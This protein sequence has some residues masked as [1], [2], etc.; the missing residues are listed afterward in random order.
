M[1]T[2]HLWRNNSSLPCLTN[3]QLEVYHD[4]TMW[5]RRKRRKLN[6]YLVKPV[7]NT[8][9]YFTAHLH[10]FFNLKNNTR[11]YNTCLFYSYIQAMKNNKWNTHKSSG[12]RGINLS[13]ESR[14]MSGRAV[15]S[16]TDG[17]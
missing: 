7:K 15:L 10:L 14:T 5:R 16:S 12:N 1:Q 17:F 2:E 11:Q 13:T 3:S 8:K 6:K 9:V 4:T